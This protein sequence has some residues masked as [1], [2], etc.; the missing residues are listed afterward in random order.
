M[1]RTVW[2][3][4]KET[5][6]REVM[7]KIRLK[8]LKKQLRYSYQNS[9][10]YRRKF[11]EVGALPEDIVTM[12]D[13][14]K[15]PVFMTKED[16]RLSEAE[17]RER[18]GHTFGMHLCAPPEDVL[19]VR[20]TTGT[21]GLAT[22]GYSH[23]K[24]EYEKFKE[25]FSRA[26]WLASLRPGDTLLNCFPATGGVHASG[27]L[28]SWVLI[29]MGI[30]PVEVGAEAGVEKALQLAML[31]KPN[32]LMASSSL[33]MTMIETCPK[34]TGME[35][36]EM[37]IRKLLLSGEAGIEL[38]NVRRKIEQGFNGKWYSWWGLYGEGNAASCDTEEYQGMHEV[39]P[40]RAISSEDLVDPLTKEPIEIV[41]GAIGEQ[42][43]TG[44]DREG[45]SFIKYATGDIVQ[46][47][48]QPCP[49]GY[50]GP[51]YRFKMLSRVEDVLIVDNVRV[52]PIFLRQVIDSFSPRLTGTMRIV[53]TE[54]PPQ[55]TS[56]LKIKLEYGHVTE[57]GQLAD[58]ERQV[59]GKIQEI[60]N[61]IPDIEFVS[62]ETLGRSVWKTSIFE[63]QF[64]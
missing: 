23:T 49:C 20:T 6:P 53:L 47:F 19:I 26:F 10:F 46:I 5:M 59:K 44:L 63:K 7:E 27:G 17:S 61:I 34:V 48:T 54:K 33:A 60:C 2:N 35:M 4:E 43:L 24:K 9:E 39:A 16:E 8:N 28:F 1:P 36:K 11:A 31:T 50:P 62:P 58:L 14:R 45:L 15:L 52:F 40:E 13:F 41:D 56:P 38:P 51:G 21:T 64:E 22:F 37:G 18:F 25:R 3:E 57:E 32:A 30:A 55:I 12:K 42:L 29:N